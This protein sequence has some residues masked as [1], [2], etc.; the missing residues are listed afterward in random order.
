MVGGAGE[1]PVKASSP[2]LGSCGSIA[3]AVACPHPPHLRVL[4]N[5]AHRDL[6]EMPEC[7]GVRCQCRRV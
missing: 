6:P 4:N 7:A 3:P 2:A 1:R 5:K